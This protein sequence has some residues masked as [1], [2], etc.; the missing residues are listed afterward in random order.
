[1]TESGISHALCLMCL[2]ARMLGIVF[3]ELLGVGKSMLIVG[4][5][6]SCARNPELDKM[7]KSY[8]NTRK[9]SLFYASWMLIQSDQMLQATVALP[10]LP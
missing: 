7:K 3:I 10:S 8:Y 5:A 6:I 1:M 2:L 9:R 4:V